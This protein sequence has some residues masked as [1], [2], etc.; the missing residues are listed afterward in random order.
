MRLIVGRCRGEVLNSVYFRLVTE[1]FFQYILYICNRTTT[2]AFC[3]AF[4]DDRIEANATSAEERMIID[5]P[6]I[7]TM[8]YILVDDLD[9][10]NGV[11]RNLQMASKSVS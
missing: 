2:S 10:I 8:Y 6:I 4:A 1:T 9:G 11:H 5:E 3:K 7:K